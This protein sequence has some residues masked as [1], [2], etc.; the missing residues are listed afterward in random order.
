MG[1]LQVCVI[2]ITICNGWHVLEILTLVLLGTEW[3]ICT[4]VKGNSHLKNIFSI[5][6]THTSK[7]GII[8]TSQREGLRKRMIKVLHF[9]SCSEF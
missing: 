7:V 4:V 6:R 5:K 3:G 1:K 9:G 8:T 2:E